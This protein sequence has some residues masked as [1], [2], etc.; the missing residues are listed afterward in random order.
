[1]L[2]VNLNILIFLVF[3]IIVYDFYFPSSTHNI[4]AGALLYVFF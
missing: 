4:A 2:K 1:M 3:V